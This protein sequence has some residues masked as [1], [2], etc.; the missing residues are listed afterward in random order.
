VIDDHG[1]R[2]HAP[3]WQ[4]Y[5]HAVRR[6]GPRPTLIEWDTDLPEAWSVLLA[7]AA[8]AERIA[9]TRWRWRHERRPP[10]E[11]LRQQMLLRALWRD[12][13]PGRCRCPARP[14]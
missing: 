14:S 3:V 11:A 4:V 13:R 12:A 1:S 8:K 10:R 6:L 9:A 5:A 2:V 7:E